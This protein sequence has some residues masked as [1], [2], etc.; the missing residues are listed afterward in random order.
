M[1]KILVFCVVA[2]SSSDINCRYF[3]GKFLIIYSF[4]LQSAVL[5]CTQPLTEMSTKEFPWTPVRLATADSFAVLAMPDVKV[6]MEAQNFI[7]PPSLHDLLRESFTFE[8]T[9]RLQFF[10][11][12]GN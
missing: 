1:L 8:R 9:Y 6:R 4:C 5:G 10:R 3:L 11:N 2:L 7:S 12:V